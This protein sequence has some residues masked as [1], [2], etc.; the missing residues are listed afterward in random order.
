MLM[1]LSWKKPSKPLDQQHHHIHQTKK[2]IISDEDCPSY[3][4][5]SMIG[6]DKKLHKSSWLIWKNIFMTGVHINLSSWSI[7]TK[8]SMNDIHESLWSVHKKVSTNGLYINVSPWIN[9]LKKPLWISIVSTNIKSLRAILWKHVSMTNL[10]ERT[11]W[12]IPMKIYFVKL[13]F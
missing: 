11:L 13:S 12:A 6:Y 10:S 4:Y 7:I 1:T 5:I 3:K 2:I 8:N 9:S